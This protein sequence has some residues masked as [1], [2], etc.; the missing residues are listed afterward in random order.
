M[1][2]AGC[3]KGS[4]DWQEP[5]AN[6][7]VEPE[8]N[9]LVRSPWNGNLAGRAIHELPARQLFHKVRIDGAGLKKRDAMLQALQVVR[10]LVKH[11]LVDAQS[12][13]RVLKRSKTA[14]SEHK[15][16]AKI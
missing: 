10:L 8:G 9:G 11:G 16:V 13:T 6:S 14:R 4:D 5:S 2:A 7:F 3:D 1:T 12:C 15:M